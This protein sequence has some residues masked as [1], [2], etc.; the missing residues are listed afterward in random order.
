M[1]LHVSVSGGFT[2]FA[3]ASLSPTYAVFSPGDVVA[4]KAQNANR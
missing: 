1:S 3:L 4:I 2:S